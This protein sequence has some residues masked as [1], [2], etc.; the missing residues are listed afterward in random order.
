M[1]SAVMQHDVIGQEVIRVIIP[2]VSEQ[3]LVVFMPSSIGFQ[4]LD[5][6]EGFIFSCRNEKK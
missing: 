4:A 6:A 1:T 3:I 5:K 2:G